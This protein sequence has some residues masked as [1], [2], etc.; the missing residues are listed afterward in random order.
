MEAPVEG[1][2]QIRIFIVLIMND[3]K[4]SNSDN[5][6]VMP[7]PLPPP[8][9]DNPSVKSPN[10]RDFLQLSEDEKI[11]Y[12]RMS[13]GPFEDKFIVNE[14]HGGGLILTTIPPKKRVWKSLT[15][16]SL[17]KANLERQSM[18]IYCNNNDLEKRLKVKS[19]PYMIIHDDI[20]LDAIVSYEDELRSIVTD[21]YNGG[22]AYCHGQYEDLKLGD[23]CHS[24]DW[25][26]LFQYGVNNLGYKVQEQDLYALGKL[27]KEMI[28]RDV[29]FVS[30]DEYY[31]VADN[32]M[33][34]KNDHNTLI[35]VF[36]RFAKDRVDG[37][38][39]ATY[40]RK[41]I[42]LNAKTIIGNMR[43]VIEFIEGTF[44][45]HPDHV[46]NDSYYYAG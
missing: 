19:Y 45:D 33:I 1:T 16:R 42:K 9:S 5:D 11:D 21:I 6:S 39:V 37:L 20:P 35:T 44:V 25:V 26:T 31:G 14:V 43:N 12:N 41:Y 29:R 46:I 36:W 40:M 2:S 23:K 3:N 15:E 27:F 30:R 4:L 28:K 8:Y 10:L 38:D 13:L 18:E 17:H 32:K 24:Y 22:V 34:S 7:P